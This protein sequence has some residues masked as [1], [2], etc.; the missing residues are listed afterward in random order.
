MHPDGMPDIGIDSLDPLAFDNL[1]I[2]QS[3]NSPVSIN[4]TMPTGRIE[5]WRDMIVTKVV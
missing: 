5:G 2:S 3:A 4:L 1:L